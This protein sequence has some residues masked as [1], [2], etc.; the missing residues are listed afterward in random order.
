MFTEP[1]LITGSNAYR[2]SNVT[3]PR[4]LVTTSDGYVECTVTTS[5]GVRLAVH[6]HGSAGAREHTIVLLHGLC[7]TQSS[8]TRQIQHL[9][10]RWGNNVRIISYDHRGHGE[11]TGADMCTYRIDRLGPS[12]LRSVYVTFSTY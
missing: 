9:V 1:E 11:S 5:D 8:W 12:A 10:R 7:L 2:S 4:R 3:P 6:D